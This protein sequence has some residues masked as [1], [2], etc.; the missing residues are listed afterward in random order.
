VDDTERAALAQLL[1]DDEQA[2]AARFRFEEHSRQFVVA[3]ARLRQQLA[4]LL[5][6]EPAGLVLAAGAHGKPRLADAHNLAGLEFNLSH[7]G[8]RGL[9]GWAWKRA[10]GVDIECWRPMSDEAA[11]VRRYF[12]VSE[13]AAYEA[14]APDARTPAFFN[15]WTRK[16]AY[17]KAVG[18][19]LGLPLDSF[20]VSLSDGA[21][22]RL[23]RLSAIGDDGRSWSLAALHLG[24]GVSAAAVTQGG[25]FRIVQACELP[26]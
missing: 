2:R 20:D 21:D 13:I 12:S 4:A 25:E 11:L 7:S 9:V 5:H 10:I 17:V 14:L 24:A 18:R 19:G 15:C 22:A 26:T 16:E 6:T 1:S 3:H 8:S 23:L